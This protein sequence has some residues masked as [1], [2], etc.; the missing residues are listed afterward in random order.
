M[1]NNKRWENTNNYF[2]SFSGLLGEN[3]HVGWIGILVISSVFKNCHIEEVLAPNNV[4]PRALIQCSG[5]SWHT[6]PVGTECPVMEAWGHFPSPHCRTHR[7]SSSF[8][9]SDDSS[10]RARKYQ[11]SPMFQ[12]LTYIIFLTDFFLSLV[13]CP[14]VHWDHPGKVY[15]PGF[16]I[17]CSRWG[18]GTGILL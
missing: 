10:P 7:L 4:L 16:W 3:T 9:K 17:H 12:N 15:T 2:K 5:G 8:F 11:M 13:I 14:D 6:P 1:R 18:T